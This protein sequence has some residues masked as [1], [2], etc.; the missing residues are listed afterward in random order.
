MDP[1]RTLSRRERQILEVVYRLGEAAVVDVL[2]ELAGPPGYDSVRTTLRFMEDKG[3]VRHRRDGQRYVYSAVVSKE[4]ARQGAMREMVRTFFDG[5][6]RAAA[7]ALLT[8][9]ETELDDQELA[10]LRTLLDD[11]E[12]GTVGES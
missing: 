10:R 1:R 5:S 8:L 7:L 4:R 9:E 2:G 11:A 6:A 3:V 12:P